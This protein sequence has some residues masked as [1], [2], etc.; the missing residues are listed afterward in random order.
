MNKHV[1]KG[2][3][4]TAAVTATQLAHAAIDVTDAVTEVQ[5]T[6]APIGLIGLAMLGVLA[7]LKAWKLVRRAL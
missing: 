4:L 5:G 1:L 2:L 7:G 3:A 6:S